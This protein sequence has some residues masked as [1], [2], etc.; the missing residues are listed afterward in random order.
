MI[1][2]VP[3]SSLWSPGQGVWWFQRRW[4][5]DSRKLKSLLIM[6]IL[7]VNFGLRLGFA[8]FVELISKYHGDVAM[9]ALG[10]GRVFRLKSQQY[11]SILLHHCYLKARIEAVLVPSPL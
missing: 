4:K 6:R 10:I 8:N 2:L 1:L 7:G 11:S 9:M 3:Y 5:G